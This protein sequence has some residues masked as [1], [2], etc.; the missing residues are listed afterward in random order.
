[1]PPGGVVRDLAPDSLRDGA[2]P[3]RRGLRGGASEQPTLRAE[4]SLRVVVHCALVPAHHRKYRAT[5]AATTAAAMPV[6]E[7]ITVEAPTLEQQ[8]QQD[9]AQAL[10]GSSLGS[11]TT[12]LLLPLL[13]LHACTPLRESL[14]LGRV[15]G[16]RVLLKLDNAQPSGSFKIRGIGHLCQVSARRGCQR[17]VCSSGGNAGLAAAYSARMLG[18]PATIYVPTT[19]PN[20]TVERLRDEGATVNIHGQMLDDTIEYAMEVAKANNWVYIPP[21]DNPLIWEGHASLVHELKASMHSKPGAIAL[22]V[23][24][25]GLMCGVVQGLR[26][27]GWE[28]VPII[29]MET[30]GADSLNAALQ[31]GKLVTLP[32][33]T[34]VAKSLGAKR[35]GAYS[36]KVANEHPVF[37]EVI[38]DQ[39][40]VKAMERFL[41]DEKILAEPAC[42]AAIAAVYSKVI[43]KLQG[44]GK[45]SWDL[46]S[47]VVIVCGGSNI[48]LK[49]LYLLKEQLGMDD[50]TSS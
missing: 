21:F 8:Q 22:S 31:A 34:S 29:A 43:Q 5:A 42:G 24:G 25:G 26:E 6:I 32:S 36:F 17:F 33:I 23:G 3:P 38:S 35:V 47:V 49:Q 14:A 4:R 30:R 15:A 37:S 20:F 7:T 46:P 9:T 18:V 1:M 12:S 2:A 44:E 27:V 48:T 11:P 50:E 16:T 10:K 13:P 40:A 19:T 39:E 28:D 41:D 45:L